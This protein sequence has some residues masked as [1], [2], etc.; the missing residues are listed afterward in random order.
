MENKERVLFV[1][2]CAVLAVVSVGIIPI[3]ASADVM[4]V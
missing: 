3:T 1:V 4:T 2:T